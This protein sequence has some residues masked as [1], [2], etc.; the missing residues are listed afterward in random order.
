MSGSKAVLGEVV[1][2]PNPALD[3]VTIVFDLRNKSDRGIQSAK[4]AMVTI[5]DAHGV[6]MGRIESQSVDAVHVN[7]STW[8]SGVYSVHV[9]SGITSRTTLFSVVH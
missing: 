8:P 5:H 3:L 2:Y 9:R 4:V 7:A 6:E 1:V